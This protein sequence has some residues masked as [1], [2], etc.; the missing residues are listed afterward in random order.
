MAQESVDGVDEGGEAVR[1]AD[2]RDHAVFAALGFGGLAATADHD[3]G[4]AAD[5]FEGVGVGEVFGGN[6]SGELAQGVA[7]SDVDAIG[8]FEAEFL[9]KN[10]QDHN[11]SSH[12]RGLSV[13]G[14]GEGGVG[15][16]G[17][18]GGEGGGEDVIHLFEEGFAGF[19]EG[20]EPRGGHANALDALA[21]GVL[22]RR[23]EVE[24]R[25]G[26]YQ[27]RIWLFWGA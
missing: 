13:F 20:F 8:G 17:D 27:E 18:D 10:A 25:R 6:K 11:G 26:S 15:A 14:G 4:P 16:G 12:D 21:F 23:A 2:K 7:E 5:H 1:L 19:G 24:G 9:F 3:L 22:V